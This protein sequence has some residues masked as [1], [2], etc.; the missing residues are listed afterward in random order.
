MTS[1]PVPSRIPNPERPRPGDRD[2]SGGPEASIDPKTGQERPGLEPV[3]GTYGG[4]APPRA[5]DREREEAFQPRPGHAE[6]APERDGTHAYTRDVQRS[7]DP[8]TR[9]MDST[10]QSGTGRADRQ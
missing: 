8:G 1:R 4:L 5:D 6:T 7:D 10:V 9:P 2:P 3:D